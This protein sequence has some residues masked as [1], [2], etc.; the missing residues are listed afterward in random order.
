MR[1]PDVPSALA[2]Y[3]EPKLG[4]NETPIGRFDPPIVAMKVAPAD[5]RVAVKSAADGKG[6]M[7]GRLHT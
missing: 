7:S 1:H 3:C 6:E 2:A 4:A 5:S